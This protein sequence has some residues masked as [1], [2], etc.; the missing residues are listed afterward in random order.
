MFLKSVENSCVSLNENFYNIS[1]LCKTISYMKI[2]CMKN[3]VNYVIFTKH[4]M[5]EIFVRE[6]FFQFRKMIS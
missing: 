6:I 5:H 4:F 2:S 1:L 3:V